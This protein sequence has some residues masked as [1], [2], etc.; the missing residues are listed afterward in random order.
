MIMRRALCLVW[1]AG[2]RAARGGARLRTVGDGVAAE[3][4][5][6]DDAAGR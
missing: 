1:E 5:H 3:A 6:R 2:R 4:R